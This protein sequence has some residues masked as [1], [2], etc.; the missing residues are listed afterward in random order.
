ML[1]EINEIENEIE[2]GGYG[3]ICGEFESLLKYF[4][5]DTNSMR[6]EII[7]EDYFNQQLLSMPK[8]NSRYNNSYYSQNR[9]QVPSQQNQNFNS[10]LNSYANN[11]MS[12]C[13]QSQ[14]NLVSG[15]N[16]SNFQNKVADTNKRI[17]TY[18]N[19]RDALMQSNLT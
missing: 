15:K 5:N 18:R 9:M 19:Q 3:Q 14:R 8:L 17:G 4:Q 7:N 13:K 12:M 10:N 6:D 2:N 1:D 16:H 11:N